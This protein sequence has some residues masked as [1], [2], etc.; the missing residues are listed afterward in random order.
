M[1]TRNSKFSVSAFSMPS[2]TAIRNVLT[3]IE[4]KPDVAVIAGC[5]PGIFYY[6]VVRDGL[7]VGWTVESCTDPVKRKEQFE[8]QT[9]FACAWASQVAESIMASRKNEN[10][11]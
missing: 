4:Q 8:L 3:V 10:V 7:V 11:H 1:T 5:E 2:A 6:V 9:D